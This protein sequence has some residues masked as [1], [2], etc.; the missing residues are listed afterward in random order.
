M[1]T[2]SGTLADLLRDL[3]AIL[4]AGVEVLS[5]EATDKKCAG[6][7]HIGW[8]WS[9]LEA[10]RV[11]MPDDLPAKVFNF[12]RGGEPVGEELVSIKY[13]QPNEARRAFSDAVIA[14]AKLEVER[15]Q[16]Q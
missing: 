10:D 14:W 15:K 6:S 4:R 12:L 5:V 11:V 7:H 3:P 2:I 13:R 9:V 1:I 8:H 16:D